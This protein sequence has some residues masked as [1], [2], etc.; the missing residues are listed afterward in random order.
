MDNFWAL[1]A[2]SRYSA[3][4]G[5][6]SVS[7]M[8]ARAKELGYKALGLTD[9][10][11]IAGVVQ[12]YNS[13]RKA[14]IEPVP[15]L[16]AYVAMDR[17]TSKRPETFHMIL[18]AYNTVGYR[19]LC[20]LVTRSNE[21]FKYKPMLDMADFAELFES[22]G[23]QGLLATTG[24]WFGLSTAVDVTSANSRSLML[25]LDHWFDGNFYVELQ[26]HRITGRDD[27]RDDPWHS[28]AMFDMANEM[29]LPMVL[30]QDSHYLYP[31]DRPVHDAMKE[32]VSWSDSPDDAVFPGDG[33]HMVDTDWMREHHS[34]ALFRAGMAGLD[35]IYSMLDVHIPE[36]DHYQLRV[37]DVTFG[38]DPDQ[39]LAHA[40]ADGL[41]QV[42]A[43]R[44]IPRSRIVEYKQRCVEE[45]EVISHSGFASYLLLVA[46]VTNFMREMGIR[47]R[48]RGS[49]SGSIVCW[50][51]SI[52]DLDPVKWQLSF[53]R[54]L[55]RDRTKPPDI[56]L[57]VEHARR[58]EVLA[59]L[60]ENYPCTGIGTVM[61]LGLKADKRN[62]DTKGSLIIAWKQ[63][64]RKVGLNPNDPIPAEWMHRLRA[65]ADYNGVTSDGTAIEPVLA[66]IGQHPAG[67]LIARS[68]ADLDEIPKAY[69][70]S[71]K[72]MVAAF[73]MN[74]VENLGLLKLDVL[75]LRTLTA[76]RLM[77]ES[78]GI[79]AEEVPLT[80]SRTYTLIGSGSTEGLFQ[81]EGWT[82]ANGCKKMKPRKIADV[83]AAM[84]LFRPAAM[85]SGATES[86]LARRR[87]D[88]PIP[89]L[90][91]MI[92]AWTADT[93]GVLVYQEQAL[94]L[95]KDIGM[96]VAEIE[97]ARKAIKASNANVASAAQTMAAMHT[98]I[99]E[100]GT[101]VGMTAADID[102]ITSALDAYANYGFNRAHA[103]AYGLLAYATAWFR[104]HHPVQFW[105]ATLVANEDAPAPYPEAER[106]EL[107]YLRT[108]RG[109]GVAV[110]GA[111]INTS[112]VSYT[113][114]GTA[115]YKGIGS[116]HGVGP[117]AAKE[118]VRAAPFKSL[119]DMARRV[120]PASVSGIRDLAKGHSPG[121]CSG[122]VKALYEAGVLGGLGRDPITGFVREHRNPIIT[123]VNRLIK[124]ETGERISRKTIGNAITELLP[125]M[126]ELKTVEEVADF[127]TVTILATDLINEIEQMEI[128]NASA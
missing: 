11:N 113:S 87:G 95:L 22:G 17:S 8:V 41:T 27:G 12:L 14:G 124:A 83:I 91:Q 51:T 69:V 70:A 118:I 76:L 37:P 16:E 101:A 9:H 63:R 48:V 23:L 74:D 24:C 68:Q 108:A 32:L 117:V 103:T 28:Q 1:H 65:I 34:P 94:G 3:K 125:S 67:V 92:T 45:L 122:V 72:T 15:G 30:A 116:I 36:L 105:T 112:A 52:T 96:S 53:D 128:T 78:T 99:V 80:D 35:R 57:D 13:A 85:G 90:H 20:R 50:L 6:P 4:D 110:V 21:N 33:Y 61:K 62:A 123:L 109:D 19:N 44:I 18:A 39:K 56:D 126:G 40:V 93:Y 49:A 7:R 10:G 77:E 100:L 81:L 54:F 86:Y 84:A 75:G 115:I 46:E 64:A 31:S 43:Q 29:G 121:A 71:S 127:V 98:R 2:H 106:P 26:N 5:M 88:E 104:V 89:A 82:A 25:A 38:A 119:D 73:D 97:K 55:S 59:W 111:N 102:W 79:R 66:S 114:D 60:N 42:E 120:S 47:Y 107:V 58:H